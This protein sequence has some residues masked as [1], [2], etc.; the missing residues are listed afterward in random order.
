[1]TH[2]RQAPTPEE[3]RSSPLSPMSPPIGR[4]G[5]N[6]RPDPMAQYEAQLNPIRQPKGPSLA[7]PIAKTVGVLALAAALGIGLSKSADHNATEA[8]ADAR[9]ELLSSELLTDLNIY[10]QLSPEDQKA[11]ECVVGR[12]GTRCAGVSRLGTDEFETQ[13]CDVAA[14]DKLDDA[15]ES[16]EENL[17]SLGIEARRIASKAGVEPR[18]MCK[19]A[20]HEA[21]LEI[22]VNKMPTRSDRIPPV[23][24]ME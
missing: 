15:G 6:S 11:L 24:D 8:G 5:R 13:H 14:L 21:T 9:A 20:G 1:M 17:I 19:T 16:K 3:Q 22:D 12:I 2:E 7:M 18:F 10:S 4:P 23:R